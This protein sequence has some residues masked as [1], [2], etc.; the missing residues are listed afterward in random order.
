M[1][2]LLVQPR[3]KGG[4]GFKSLSV[5]EPLALEAIAACLTEKHEVKI[6]DFFT[7][8]ELRSLLASFKPDLCGISCGF[9]IDVYKSL[10]IAKNVRNSSPKTKIVVGGHHATMN[11]YDFY[12][13]SID[14]VV[15]GEGEV[16]TPALVD[17]LERGGDLREVSGLILNEPDGQHFTGNRPPVRDLDALPIPARHLTKQYRKDYYLTFW[18]PVTTLETARGCPFRCNYCSVWKFYQGKCRT[19]SPEW[20]IEALKG[21]KEH[22][23]MFTDDNFLL[24]IPRA[25]R[26][27]ALIKES[28][29]KKA[30][31]FQARSDSIVKHPEVITEWRQVGLENLFIGLEAIDDAALA[32]LNKKNDVQNNEAALEIT[33]A[34]GIGVTA[35]FI[36][37]PQYTTEE[38]DKLR[39]YV[40]RLKDN[41]RHVVPSFSVLTPL[42]GTDLA[43]QIG[44]TIATKNYELFDLMHSVMPTKLELP[45]FYKEFASLFAVGYTP[46]KVLKEGLLPMFSNLMGR[47]LTPRHLGRMIAAARMITGARFYM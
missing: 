32:S 16:T 27:A 12:K 11:A 24:D 25:R 42:P 30:Y 18:R 29:I 41:F 33:N 9:T 2:I 38:F 15:V 47:K 23:I 3:Q 45:D 6:L 4:V 7:D 40:R 39:R 36:V 35:A 10:S 37:N 17:C 21:I 14:F 13:D 20:T 31:F 34:H 44:D 43:H 19:R 22:Y 26:I 5:V 46:Y 28:G 1:R 8:L